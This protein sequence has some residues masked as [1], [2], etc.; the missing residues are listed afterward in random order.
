V[1]LKLGDVVLDDLQQQSQT[2]DM[3]A[4]ISFNRV[5]VFPL[6]KV[7]VLSGPSHVCSPDGE[8]FQ[9]DSPYWQHRIP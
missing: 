4:D 7:R 3:L 6:V 1:D 2:G 9:S 5:G 8:M